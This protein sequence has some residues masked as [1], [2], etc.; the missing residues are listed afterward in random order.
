MTNNVQRFCFLLATCSVLG[1]GLGAA[2]SQT[3]QAQ[4]FAPN[5]TD[6]CFTD[7][8]SNLVEGMV[9]G[10]MVGVCA[11]VAVSWNT[12]LKSDRP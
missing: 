9:Q 5:S 8:R 7:N 10:L 3:A 4:C 2:T 1:L 12:L 6:R 11:A